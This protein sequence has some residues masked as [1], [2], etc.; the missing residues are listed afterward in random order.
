[1][2]LRVSLPQLNVH[3]TVP[4]ALTIRE[5]PGS[6]YQRQATIPNAGTYILD[7]L[8]S[9]ECWIEIRYA[10]GE[11]EYATGWISAIVTKFDYD[12]HLTKPKKILTRELD[13]DDVY[14]LVSRSTYKISTPSARGTAVAISPTVLLTNCHVLEEYDTVQILEDGDSHKANLIH[15]DKSKDKCFIRSLTLEV[16]PVPNV[17]EFSNIRMGVQAYTIGAPLGFNR[18]IGEGAVVEEGEEE[19]VRWIISTA[20][21]EPG[22]SGGGLFDAKGNLLGIT[23][24][25]L[26]ALDGQNYSASIAADDFWQ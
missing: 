9:H 20:P 23:T 8:D 16:R 17:Q 4:A 26:T 14:E 12:N 1:M 10:V 7:L 2:S 15:D 5:G 24:L 22:S 13:A 19:G 25:K 21:V 6:N 3:I 11:G 18:S